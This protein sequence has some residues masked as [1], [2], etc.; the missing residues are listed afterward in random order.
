[1][2]A[3]V[4]EVADYGIRLRSAA[5]HFQVRHTRYTHKYVAHV[6]TELPC[7][8]LWC[9]RARARVCVCLF[10]R[11][12]FVCPSCSISVVVARIFARQAD[13]D[14]VL[15]AVSQDYRALQHASTCLQA[16]E[17]VVAAA[18]AQSPDAL[19][20]ASAELRADS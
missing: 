6:S 8:A 15:V 2:V 1:M 17:T 19:A 14:V 9:E 3:Q 11:V 10:A 16:D 18:A 4:W 5:K 12:L 13:R 7:S 20:H